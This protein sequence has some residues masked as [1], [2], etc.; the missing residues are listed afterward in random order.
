MHVVVLMLLFY[1]YIPRAGVFK[2]PHNNAFFLP[3]G[4]YN[5]DVETFVNVTILSLVAYV[6]GS[7]YSIDNLSLREL[8]S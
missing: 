5:Y 2:P 7:A 4:S 6:S 3:N 8:V 1:D